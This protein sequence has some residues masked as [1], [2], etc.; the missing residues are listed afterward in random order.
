MEVEEERAWSSEAVRQEFLFWARPSADSSC[1][2]SGGGSI[3]DVR[4]V[5]RLCQALSTRM[6]ARLAQFRQRHIGVPILIAYQADATSFLIQ[7]RQR[8]GHKD[9]Q[10]ITRG[11]QDLCE[12]LSERIFAAS[13]RDGAVHDQMVMTCVPRLLHVDKTANTHVAAM[14]DVLEH[15][16]SHDLRESIA[17]SFFSW[18]RAVLAPCMRLTQQTRELFWMELG[19]VMYGED[20]QVARD[21]DLCL[22]TGCALHDA[23]SGLRW[24]TQQLLEADEFKQLYLLVEGLRCGARHLYKVVDMFLDSCLVIDSDSEWTVEQAQQFWSFLGLSGEMLDE[25]AL[26]RPRWISGKLH[27]VAVPGNSNATMHARMTA[28][29]AFPWCWRKFNTARWLTLGHGSRCLCIAHLLGLPE[30]SRLARAQPGASDFW[31]H[32]LDN[33]SARLA[34]FCCICGPGACVA[35]ALSLSL[36]EDPRVAGRAS[37]FTDILK[38]Q[39]DWLESAESWIWRVLVD[40]VEQESHWSCIR[41]Q[42][43]HAAQVTAASCPRPF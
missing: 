24:G 25:Y 41:D 22:G 5:S 11:A 29:V 14:R 32:H 21:R 2:D 43:V 38:T 33:W 27:I 6:H 13:E 39:I 15:P 37:D 3:R 12:Y 23:A 28:V 30:I 42:S 34:R 26:L 19:S 7:F 4:R 18:D 10:V 9:G 17:V 35:D 16:F 40:T 31:L 20:V 1:C 36:M 8:L